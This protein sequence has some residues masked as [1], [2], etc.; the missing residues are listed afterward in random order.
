MPDD[1]TEDGRPPLS[2]VPTPVEAPSDADAD[3]PSNRLPVDLEE[4]EESA[5]ADVTESEARELE[6]ASVER[7]ANEPALRRELMALQQA[8]QRRDITADEL[9]E[10]TARR[11][12]EYLQG[13]GC[14]LRL[15]SPTRHVYVP[16]GTGRVIDV[17]EK[18]PPWRDYIAHLMDATPNPRFR[19]AVARSAMVARAVPE[20]VSEVRFGTWDG[21]SF[22]VPTACGRLMRIGADEIDLVENP[23]G[24]LLFMPG[25]DWALPTIDALDADDADLLPLAK[26]VTRGWSFDPEAAATPEEQG[27]LVLAWT[28]LPLVGSLVPIKPILLAQGPNGAGKSTG[29]KTIGQLL[30]GE[31]FDVTEEGGPL[32]FRAMLCSMPLVVLDNIDTRVSWL[33][34][35]LCRASSG[36]MPA[37]RQYYTTNALVR[38]RADAVVAITARTPRFRRPDV[39]D[40]LLIIRLANRRQAGLPFASTRQLQ[41]TMRADR[42]LFWRGIARGLRRLAQ[43]MKEGLQPVPVSTRLADFAEV[44][45]A[46]CGIF[47]LR[48]EFVGGLKA[49]ERERAEFAPADLPQERVDR[50]DDLREALTTWAID[51]PVRAARGLAA[52]ELAEIL[53]A[54]G[55]PEHGGAPMS[56]VTLGR[57]LGRLS[58]DRG[59]A[60]DVEG[61]VIDGLTRWS[62]RQ[63]LEVQTAAVGTPV[64]KE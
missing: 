6:R 3:R 44:G 59:G 46:I 33:E 17:D 20:V 40:R 41:K 4:P 35:A 14:F 32:D 52:R 16:A 5:F 8:Q 13:H 48:E 19:A 62:V 28:F 31:E 29:L 15:A 21:T 60:L 56:P 37:T 22:F 64:E 38:H 23:H 47:G 36:Q 9:N 43:Q 53:A 51:D 55:Y 42:T 18:S 45:A 10:R 50:L 24:R 30:L 34:N 11:V 54:L 39:A 27:A 63:R 12:V 1:T 61:R 58:L 49:M 25:D 7:L 26:L 2:L 57:A